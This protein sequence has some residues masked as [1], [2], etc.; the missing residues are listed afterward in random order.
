MHVEL[1]GLRLLLV[2]EMVIGQEVVELIHHWR[3]GVSPFWEAGHL[4]GEGVRIGTGRVRVS[5]VTGS[6]ANPL[7]QHRTDPRLFMALT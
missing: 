7:H 6:A 1:D 4:A 5:D 2:F 3:G